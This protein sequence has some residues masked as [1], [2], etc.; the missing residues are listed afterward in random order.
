MTSPSIPRRGFAQGC[1]AR[2]PSGPVART[3]ATRRWSRKTCVTYGS[4]HG[5]NACSR[6]SAYALRSFRKNPV[7]TGV[8]A[9]SLAL[10]IGGNTAI[11]SFMDAI[12]LRALP[13]HRADELVILN[14]QTK[15]MP[16]VVHGLSGTWYGDRTI[17][18]TSGNYPY[19]AFELLRANNTVLADMFGFV[20]LGR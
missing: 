5:S 11:Y 9:L 16:A 19:P 10:G 14:W 8:A 6:T 13:V 4:G 15:G 12:L 20:E 1:R 18:F 2:R 7:F 17:G 3:S